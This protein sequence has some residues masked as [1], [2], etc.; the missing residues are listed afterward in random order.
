MSTIH[1]VDAP[2]QRLRGEPKGWRGALMAGS[3]LICAWGGTVAAQ[4]APPPPPADT[5][6]TIGEITV[7]ARHRDE[8][9]QKVP[10]AVSVVGGLDAASKNLNDIQDISSIVPSVDFRTSASNKDRTIFVR[11]VGTISTSPGV[12]PSVST[13]VDGVVMSRAG[14]STVDL[15]DLDHVEVLEGPQGTL[16]GK[17]ATAGVINII[18][19]RPTD[20]FKGYVDAGAYGGGEYRLGVGVSGPII[21]DKLE[22]L[23]SVFTSQFGGN[24]KNLDTGKEVN[25]YV[26]DGLRGKIVAHPFEHVKVTLSADYVR[27]ADSTPTGVYAATN[28]IAY[29]TDAVTT[30]API[31]ASLAAAGVTPSFSN[32]TISDNDS[33]SVHDHNGGA[34]MQIDW[35]VGD[36]YQL[37][38]ISAWR[39]WRNVQYQDYDELSG[40]AAA[41]LP[42]VADTGY[43]HFFQESEELRIASP[44]GRLVDF[45]AGLFV[46]NAIDHELY[47]RAETSI[48]GGVPTNNLGANHY[49]SSDQNYAVFGEADLN[50]TKRFRLIAGARGIQD[51]LSYYASRVSTSPTALTGIGVSYTAPNG[52]TSPT[53]IT[54]N[55]FAGRF[56]AQYDITDNITTYATYSRGYM[57]PAFD[58]FFN[59][60]AVNT[61]PLNP[62][63]S[64]SYEVGLKSQLFDHRLQA[65]VSAFITDFYN[66][67]ANFTQLVNGGLVTNLINAGSVTS[68]GAEVS[69]LAKPIPRLTLTADAAYDDAYV[70]SFPCPAGSAVNCNINGQPLPFAPRYKAH[71]QAEYRWPLAGRFDLDVESDYNWQSKTQYQLAE[72]PQTIQSAYGIWNATIGLLDDHDGFSAHLVA[73]NIADQNYSPYIAGG[74]LGGIV[75]WVPRDNHGYVGVNL[76]KDF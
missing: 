16:F 40:A 37:T 54:R 74:D 61:P 70:V 23:L 12:E 4:I 34:S 73:K 21:P 6:V 39:D 10:I 1:T 66:Y 15:L 26:H 35:D 69:L 50:L 71:L 47:E 42:Q 55:G 32:T 25:G 14:Q 5:G 27:S 51:D 20:T 52:S 60:A 19:R 3:A 67:Q 31:A 22:G 53:A 72:T 2:G 59:M 17:N 33:S 68:R 7:T 48:I 56:G 9:L 41:G 13:V 64:D 30:H 57:G 49:G 28:N 45:V 44:K 18:T 11:G 38:S 8:S 46:L 43:L 63:T 29:Q 65:D 24:V 62:E 76:R 36:G 75:R 58:V